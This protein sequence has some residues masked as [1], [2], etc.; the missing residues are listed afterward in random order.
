M[1]FR[2]KN[3]E[4]TKFS[5]NAADTSGVALT[6]GQLVVSSGDLL[7][8]YQLLRSHPALFSAYMKTE[9]GRRVEPM[10]EERMEELSI[11]KNDGMVIGRVEG[12]SQRRRRSISCRSFMDGQV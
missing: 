3:V 10:P 9:D 2:L 5:A 11:S 1:G 4:L 6:V 12:G 7:S 8:L